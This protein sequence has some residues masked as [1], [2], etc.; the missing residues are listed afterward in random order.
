M[1]HTATDQQGDKNTGAHQQSGTG[2]SKKQ[3]AEAK[4]E[5]EQEIEGKGSSK[6]KKTP[7]TETNSR[8]S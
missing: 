2:C 1:K 8:G 4:N 5:H 6:G 3:T 7:G